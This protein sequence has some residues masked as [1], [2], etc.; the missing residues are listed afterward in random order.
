MNAE[1]KKAKEK[2]NMLLYSTCAHDYMKSQVN[3]ALNTA[4]YPSL[5]PRLLYQGRHGI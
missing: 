2:Q 1:K 4:A 3:I 5:L